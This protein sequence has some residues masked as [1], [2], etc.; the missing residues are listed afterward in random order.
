MK[1]LIIQYS[2]DLYVEMPCYSYK[3]ECQA[4]AKILYMLTKNNVPTYDLPGSYDN[5]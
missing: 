3:H 1:K 4:F 5:S 2:V